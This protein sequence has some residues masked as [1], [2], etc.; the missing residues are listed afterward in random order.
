[1]GVCNPLKICVFG[2]LPMSMTK[3]YLR[4][5]ERKNMGTWNRAYYWPEDKRV[6]VH[7]ALGKR[8]GANKRAGDCWCHEECFKN[9]VGRR[10]FPR[11]EGSDGKRA[12][13]WKGPGGRG[14]GSRSGDHPHG[15]I[16]PGG[17]KTRERIVSLN[18]DMG[19]NNYYEQ[20]LSELESHLESNSWKARYNISSIRV[21]TRNVKDQPDIVIAHIGDEP[22]PFTYVVIT[23]TNRNRA[24]YSPP[25]RTIVNTIHFDI[26][27]W[28]AE[29]IVS[30]G[31]ESQWLGD[32]RFREEWKALV[33][34]EERQ[35]VLERERILENRSRLKS[36]EKYG[37]IPTTWDISLIHD[38]DFVKDFFIENE[39]EIEKLEM[40]V[41]EDLKEEERQEKRRKKQEERE[42]REAA[43]KKFEQDD[44]KRI[45]KQ[46]K[47]SYSRK[48]LVERLNIQLSNGVRGPYSRTLR[49][50]KLHATDE[51]NRF[52]RG[53]SKRIYISKPRLAKIAPSRD[54]RK[55]FHDGYLDIERLVKKAESE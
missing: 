34:K 26:Y 38:D 24:I 41:F 43:E 14:S 20:F 11:K 10:I 40:Q 28:T 22:R 27:Q 42:K 48:P 36:L 18:E 52:I 37:K 5:Y 44:I 50:I 6:D 25:E 31:A 39:E 19:P 17:C 4:V 35:I 53:E 8:V 12:H 55:I 33:Q 15:E 2:N 3:S 51:L 1:M 9:K 29:N 54:I 16:Q 47:V 49:K 30:V 45:A 13:F 32:K 21:P 46:K 7:Y 23:N